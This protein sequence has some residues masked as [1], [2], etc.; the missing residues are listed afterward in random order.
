M[1]GRPSM[2]RA[3]PVWAGLSALC[4][5][6]LGAIGTPAHAGVDKCQVEG[7]S[8]DAVYQL[9][10][11]KKLSILVV[12]AGSSLLPGQNGAQSS[13]PERLKLAL[14]KKLTGV[15]VSVTTDVAPKRTAIEMLKTLK[16]SLTSSTPALMIWQT[17]TVDA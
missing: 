1:K 15:A 10:R 9:K 17:A 6:L 7:A 2:L 11:D 16:A 8:N 12:G 14:E 5:V 13:Y 4:L 3:M